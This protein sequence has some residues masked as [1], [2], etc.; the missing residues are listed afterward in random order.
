MGQELE[1]IEDLTGARFWRKDKNYF[2]Q[3]E[4]SLLGPIT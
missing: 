4:D 3:K 2:F 1:F